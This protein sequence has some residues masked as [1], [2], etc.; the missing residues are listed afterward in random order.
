MYAWSPN[1]FPGE[2]P[3]DKD[4]HNSRIYHNSTAGDVVFGV[5]VAQFN[6]HFQLTE[7]ISDGGGASAVIVYCCCPLCHKILLNYH[8]PIIPR[9]A[10]EKYESKGRRRM[11]G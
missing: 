3:G 6:I 4:S 11:G 1:Y 10:G 2:I 8:Q 7:V 5:T 9:S